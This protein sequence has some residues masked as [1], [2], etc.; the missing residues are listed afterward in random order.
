MTAAKEKVG[1]GYRTCNVVATERK[2]DAMVPMAVKLYST[3]A[4][5]HVSENDE[6]LKTTDMVSEA[7]GK[8]GF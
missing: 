4:P 5:E 8:K 3:G 2:G 6:I 7:A 1:N